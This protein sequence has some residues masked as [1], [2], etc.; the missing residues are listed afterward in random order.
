MKGCLGRAA[1]RSAAQR[2]AVRRGDARRIFRL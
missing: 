2:D 1:V